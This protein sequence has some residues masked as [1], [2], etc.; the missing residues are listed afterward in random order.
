MTSEITAALIAFGGSLVGTLGGILASARLTNHR[1][2]QLER[3]VDKHNNVV[4][5]MYV[6]ETRVDNICDV[7][8]EF[9]E[10]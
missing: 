9:K 3:K 1:I 6:V 5:R 4:E 8:K 7:I 2:E 10:K